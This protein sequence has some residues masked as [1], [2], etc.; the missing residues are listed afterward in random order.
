MEEGDLELGVWL[1]LLDEELV[2]LLAQ[3]L[4]HGQRVNQ[5]SLDLRNGLLHFCKSQSI[6]QVYS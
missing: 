6:D 1:A 4:V 3:S 2:C 5:R